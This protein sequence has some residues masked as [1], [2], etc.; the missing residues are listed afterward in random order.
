[1]SLECGFNKLSIVSM[2]FCS[3]SGS[4]VK[5]DQ[6]INENSRLAELIH[7]VI[8]II[9]KYMTSFLLVLWVCGGKPRK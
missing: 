3:V 6:Q 7:K 4:V 5:F 2:E 8:N 1:M 9:S